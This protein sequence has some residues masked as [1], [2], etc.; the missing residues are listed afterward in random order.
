A[1]GNAQSQR[2]APCRRSPR[3]MTQ[4]V[5]FVC[6][7]NI[8]RSPLAAALLERALKEHGLDV[9]VTSAGTGAWDGAP[10]SEGAYLVGLERGLDLSGHRARLLTRE[11]VGQAD[12]LP[13]EQSRA[14][15]G[16]GEPTLEIGRAHV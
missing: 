7:G 6:T 8:C 4:H 2:A 16:E 5:L 13:G 1:R 10:A 9:N 11:L 14:V 12:E 3:S 15:T